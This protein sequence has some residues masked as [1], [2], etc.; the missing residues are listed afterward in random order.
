MKRKWLAMG[1]ILLFVGV[2]IAPT[3][4]QNTEK[5]SSTRGNWLYVGGDGPGNF[6]KIQDAINNASNGDTVYV[7]AKSYHERIFIN[8]TLLLIGENRNDTEII[9]EPKSTTLNVNKQGSLI[10]GFKIEQGNPIVK[11][12]SNNTTFSNNIVT[13]GEWGILLD[14]VSGNN[15][16]NNIITHIHSDNVPGLGI[17]AYCNQSNFENNSLSYCDCG[18]YIDGSL[19]RIHSNIISNSWEFGL[20]TTTGAD[21]NKIMNCSSGVGGTGKISYNLIENCGLG[22]SGGY[23]ANISYNTIRNC[24]TG[25]EANS[26]NIHI[27]YNNFINISLEAFFLFEEVKP[28]HNYWYGNYWEKPRLFPKVIFGYLRYNPYIGFGI[29]WINFDWHPAQEPYDIPGMT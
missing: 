12:T 16:E 9:G 8:K 23:N 29:P 4:A 1:I 22:I 7:Y 17:E 11:V 10:S 20:G 26:V 5:Q 2:T 3:I 19:D 28:A 24:S 25:L 27:S 14:C 13:N 21:H 18:M 6:T 15:I